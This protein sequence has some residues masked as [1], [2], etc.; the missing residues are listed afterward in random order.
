MQKLSEEIT[1]VFTPSIFSN[2]EDG[3][4]M[5]S[6]FSGKFN[7]RLE[8]IRKRIKIDNI[9]IVRDAVFF[10]N[11]KQTDDIERRIVINAVAGDIA[12][13]FSKKE[14]RIRF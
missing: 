7:I 12:F 13:K 11:F 8:K 1:P 2:R 6:I 9:S 14:A 4:I 10:L 5:S 3:I